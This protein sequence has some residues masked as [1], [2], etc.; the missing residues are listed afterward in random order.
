VNIDADEIHVWFASADVSAEALD[1]LSRCLSAEERQRAGRFRLQ[2]DRARSI[3][4]RAV[5]RRLLGWYSG[6]RPES[7]NFTCGDHGKPELPG[8]PLEFNVSHSGRLIA[9]AVAVGTPVGTDIEEIR[10][11]E[12]ASSMARRFFS[13]E[14]ADCVGR[15]VDVDEAFFAIWTAREALVKGVGSGLGG[16]WPS[17]TVGRPTSTFTPVTFDVAAPAGLRNWCVRALDAPAGYRAALAARG[18]PWRLTVRECET[19]RPGPGAAG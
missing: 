4:G 7:F 10:P 1:A 2:S 17:F 12:E 11:M 13:P 19:D 16:P 8:R 6:T 5:L 9:I 14:E 18:G 3:V 15:A